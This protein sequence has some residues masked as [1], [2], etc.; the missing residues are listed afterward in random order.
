MSYQKTVWRNN[1]VITT[2]GMNNIEDGLEQLIND[3][4][5]NENK[6]NVINENS[7]NN[8]F[9]SAKAVYDLF[10]SIPNVTN[11]KY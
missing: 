1:M 10:N 2:E 4:E 5:K 7:T 11:K 9:P 3:A 8:T 6:V